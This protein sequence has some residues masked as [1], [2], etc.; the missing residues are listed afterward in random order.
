LGLGPALPFRTHLS[1]D[2][3]CIL[4]DLRVPVSRIWFHKEKFISPGKRIKYLKAEKII[5]AAR[6]IVHI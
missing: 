5:I 6:A 4:L 1:G 3:H 2:G